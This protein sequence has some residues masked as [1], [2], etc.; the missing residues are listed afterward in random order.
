MSD[1]AALRDRP[2]PAPP[3]TDEGELR[4]MLEQTWR[5]PRGW[6]GWFTAVG[7][8]TIG[9]RYVVTA[10]VFFALGGLEALV[11][12]LQL[13]R[14]ESKLVS[15][16]LYNQLFTTHGSTMMFLFAVPVMLGMGIILVPPMVGTREVAFP[17]LNAF[18][19]YMFLFG[20]L[21]LYAGFFTR[22]GPDAGW[23]AYT[24]LSGPGYAA[25]KRVDVW[26]QMITFTELSA[27]AV[28]ANLIVTILKQRAPGMSLARMPLFVWAMLVTCFMIVFAMPSVMLA[29]TALLLDRLVGTHFFNHAE[30][31][32][33]LLWQHLFWFFAHPEVYII[34][35]PAVG[36]MSELVSTFSR[37]K[38]FGYHALVLSA[39][40]T[41]FVGFGVWV[42]HMFATGLPEL[43]ESYFTASSLLITIPSGVQVF[44]W[45]ATMWGG[46]LRFSTPLLFALGFF[47][48]F[49]AGGLTGVMLA[50]VPLD[51]QVHD[52]FFVVA[53]LHYVLIGGSVFPLL[54]G[55]YFW[56]P[57]L[58]GRMMN[59]T[60]G[61]W[62]FWLLL[63][64][65]NLTFFPMHQLG[66]H[67]MPR[68]I[69][70]YP[71]ESG[72]ASL[73]LLA[74]AG[75]V[76]IAL[77]LALTLVNVLRS[78]R[79]GAVAGANP[80]DAAG[81]EWSIPSPPPCYAFLYLPVVESRQPLWDRPAA[82]LAI[83]T[84]LHADRRE[85]LVTTL[86]DARPDH[87]KQELASSAAP[88][89][90]ALGLGVGF[91]ASIFTAWGGVLAAG[92]AL[93]VGAAWFWPHSRDVH[94]EEL[95][96]R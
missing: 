41:G 6:L 68:R 96:P 50:S 25:G 89:L 15:P 58:T 52:T 2:H 54:G 47:T 20:G 76:L 60:A 71:E 7:H 38:P 43:G 88:F 92:L 4:A 66:L 94:P 95:A 40:S 65:F 57:K 73:N 23:F 80:W 42:H 13:A 55:L 93:V 77:A 12:R 91:V 8:R 44:C 51:L 9:V 17:R 72:W 64:G 27:L 34:F 29:S 26:A 45:L 30:G 81:L 79:H 32:D 31:G 21:L 19:Y 48:V 83:V 22:T 53:H 69:Y 3:P 11:M 1:P 62:S 90:M 36:M 14:P 5:E 18:S 16:D 82:E 33:H 10:F 70:T 86:L 63:V 75:A 85:V 67:G 61:K 74:T 46:K 39:V 87:R 78:R 28:A 35:L 56:F 59:E 37:R 24:P 49:I 84:G